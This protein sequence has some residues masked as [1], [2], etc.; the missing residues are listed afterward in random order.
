MNHIF[1]R[2]SYVLSEWKSTFLE[3]LYEEAAIRTGLYLC[4]FA[5]EKCRAVVMKPHQASWFETC[6]HNT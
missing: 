2:G 1:C 5:V 6:L 4:E 3:E